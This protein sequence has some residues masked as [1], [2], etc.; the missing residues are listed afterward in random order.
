MVFNKSGRLLLESHAFKL[1]E[2]T[3]KPT[4]EY[5]YLGIKFALSGSFKTAIV[6]LRGGGPT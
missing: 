1:G 2:K 6:T 4:K 3:L 5:T